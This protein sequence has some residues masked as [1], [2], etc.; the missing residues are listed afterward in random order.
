MSS[1]L[2]DFRG[3]VFHADHDHYDDARRVFNGLFEAHRP[4]LIAR[5]ADARDVALALRYAD[6]HGLAVAVR[7]GG[8]SVAGFST[9]HDGLVIDLSA[10]RSVEVAS[11]ARRVCVGPGATWRDVDVETQRFGLAAP[12]GVVSHTGV[13]GLT[14]NGG[15]GWLRNRY[16]LSC[17]NLVRAE[18]VTA[19]GERIVASPDDHPDLYWALRGGGG[20]FGVVTSFELSLHEV[21]PEVAATFAM[22][23]LARASEIL[24]AWRPWTDTA[25]P[26][27]TSE[28]V[29][30][31]MPDWPEVAEA[32]R[33]QPVVIPSAVWAG[34]ADDGLEALEPLRQFGD[35]RH[36]ISGRMPFVEVQ[37]LFD[38][39]MPN[40]G[41]VLAYWKS[42][43][44]ES[45]SDDVIALLSDLAHHR[46]I[47]STM[48]VVQHI[49][50]AVRSID[51]AE[52]AFRTRNAAFVVNLMGM[53]KDQAENE[54][55]VKWVRDAWRRLHP[56][57]TG[58]T[59]L[60]YTGAESVADVVEAT[61]RSFAEN[62]DRLRAVKHRFDPHN[63]FRLNQNVLPAG[64]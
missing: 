49:G 26:N 19:A 4:R 3:T 2:R 17:D 40:D 62:L 27:A 42:L 23:P 29:L 39:F 63:V 15:I 60:N 9:L 31:T 30:W 18:V 16:G 25:G 36:E 56:H 43:F 48:I 64:A 1:D 46:S 52:T 6:A 51:P 24:R 57:S 41:S 10:L 53:W 13:A 21:G 61:R 59:Y 11:E 14:L 55:H 32:V 54:V 47:A 22:Y 44:F 7:S 50:E 38:A 37:S 58:T 20:N 28:V 34:A 45:L 5:C 12:G 33:G 8:H 35:R